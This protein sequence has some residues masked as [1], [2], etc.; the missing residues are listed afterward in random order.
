MWH[1]IEKLRNQ[2]I[3]YYKSGIITHTQASERILALEEVKKEYEMFEEFKI[4]CL[5]EAYKREH[6]E[7]EQ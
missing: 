1:I 5:Y 4:D 2:Y 3:E 7:E 6:H